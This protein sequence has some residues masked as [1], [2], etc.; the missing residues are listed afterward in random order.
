MKEMNK[1]GKKDKKT[2]SW[3]AEKTDY[4]KELNLVN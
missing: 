4:L 3:T 2:E 1:V